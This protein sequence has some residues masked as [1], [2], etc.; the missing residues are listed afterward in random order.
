MWVGS[1]IDHDGNTS[2]RAGVFKNLGWTT[3]AF[4]FDIYNV[5]EPITF[6]LDADGSFS[7]IKDG[8]TTWSA[9]TVDYDGAGGSATGVVP[10]GWS[11]YLAYAAKN[12]V[13]KKFQTLI[14]R[15]M[16]IHTSRSVWHNTWVC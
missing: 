7:W 9:S 1:Q 16:R 15:G 4:N 14:N 2:S 5:N 13:T 10:S 11:V 8:E 12:S 3:S 6:K